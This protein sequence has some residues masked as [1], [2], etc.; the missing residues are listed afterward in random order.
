MQSSFR[1]N[2]P[3]LRML[4]TETRSIGFGRSGVRLSP[5]ESLSPGERA[6]SLP[7]GSFDATLR[8]ISVLDEASSA[9]KRGDLVFAYPVAGIPMCWEVKTGGAGAG[10]GLRF[11]GRIKVGDEAAFARTFAPVAAQ[12][13]RVGA[14]Q[15]DED[16][17]QAVE[18]WI[19]AFLPRLEANSDGDLNPGFD[20][21]LWT[22]RMEEGAGELPFLV[23]GL[24]FEVHRVI[25]V[26]GGESVHGTESI[27]R[28]LL[29]LCATKATEDGGIVKIAKTFSRKGRIR[30]RIPLSAPAVRSGDSLGFDLQSARSGVVTLLAVDES[31]EIVP[32][33]PA[34][35][36][37][38]PAIEAGESVPVGEKGSR[39]IEDLREQGQA[40][41]RDALLV[42][43]SEEA[44]LSA[45]PELVDGALAPEAAKSLLEKL[46]ALDYGFWS[47]DTV[48]FDIV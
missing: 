12:C 43:V 47:A 28:R 10:S 6:F 3:L 22:R 21:V 7:R 40:G 31:E 46:E 37:P 19:R 24:S 41:G 25:W 35:Q 5:G 32:L 11:G 48:E 29:S 44:V 14:V 38:K 2:A 27:G 17:S 1:A 30:E 20:P 33:L 26:P 18:V 13:G 42:I 34:P 39:W 8:R 4:K 45:T 23:R 15:L 36:A 9:V 16:L